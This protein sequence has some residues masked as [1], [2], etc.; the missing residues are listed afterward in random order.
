MSDSPK[1]QEPDYRY[2]DS[3]P[4]LVARLEHVTAYADRLQILLKRVYHEAYDA[5]AFAKLEV[6]Q[7]WREVAAEV[8]K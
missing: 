1:P 6:Q 5:S 7:L 2:G 3:D 8:L 4:Y